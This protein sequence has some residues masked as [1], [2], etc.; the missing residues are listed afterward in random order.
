MLFLTSTQYCALLLLSLCTHTHTRPS[1]RCLISPINSPPPNY[2]T[3]LSLHSTITYFIYLLDTL[4]SHSYKGFFQKQHDDRS[5][6]LVRVRCVIRL[7]LESPNCTPL[8][9]RS[10]SICPIYTYALFNLVDMT[11]P[12]TIIIILARFNFAENGSCTFEKHLLHCISRQCTCFQEH[13]F[14]KRKCYYYMLFFSIRI[15]YTYHFL[16]R[17]GSL[18]DKILHVHHLPCLLCCQRGSSPI[19]DW[20]TYAHPLAMIVHRETSLYYKDKTKRVCVSLH[21]IH[22]CMSPFIPPSFQHPPLSLPRFIIPTC[23]YRILPAHPLHRES[24]FVLM[25]C[26]KKSIR[27]RILCL[28]AV[29]LAE[30][31]PR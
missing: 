12:N 13:H 6:L 15:Y 8:P 24:S 5:F 20:P 25:I 22:S 1:Y 19:L 16:E 7:R 26:R 23:K 2:Y 18:P 14:C 3:A 11:F 29:A 28:V 30:T 4:Y 21:I 10:G 27:C 9:L 17:I 31:V